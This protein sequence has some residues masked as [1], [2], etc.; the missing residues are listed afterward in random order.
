MVPEKIH[1]APPEEIGSSR[2]DLGGGGAGTKVI[3]LI[4]QGGGGAPKGN[5]FS[6]FSWH[7]RE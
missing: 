5:V 4:L 1:T 2:G 3:Y 7:V 6:G